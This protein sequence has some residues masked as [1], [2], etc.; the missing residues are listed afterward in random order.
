M[1]LEKVP[2]GK[3]QGSVKSY[4]VKIEKSACQCREKER[5]WVET[6]S[7]RKSREGMG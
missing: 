1:K 4:T 6:R 2:L 7:E 3:M 5:N